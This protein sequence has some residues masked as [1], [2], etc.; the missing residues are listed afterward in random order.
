MTTTAIHDPGSGSLQL[1][2]GVRQTVIQKGR[3]LTQELQRRVEELHDTLH[4]P[5]QDLI[6]S[7]LQEQADECKNNHTIISSTTSRS[8]LNGH[9]RSSR[10]THRG[11]TD[12]VLPLVQ[13]AIVSPSEN[14]IVIPPLGGPL[15][16]HLPLYELRAVVDLSL[17]CNG[18][19]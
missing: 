4:S 5:C 11:H 9:E 15:A 3:E 14:V 2:R 7:N 1:P 6:P 12:A 13:V 17:I 18:T 10:R 8:Y 16:R 19:L